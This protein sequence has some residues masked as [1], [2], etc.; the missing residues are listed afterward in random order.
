MRNYSKAAL[1]CLVL[2]TQACTLTLPNNLVKGTTTVT[3]TDGNGGTVSGKEDCN[4]LFFKYDLNSDKQLSEDEYIKGRL[5]NVKQDDGST[6]GTVVATGGV[7][8]E[9][10]KAPTREERREVLDVR[11]IED[12]IRAGFKAMD[13][14]QNGALSREEFLL[15]CG[16]EAT[17]TPKPKPSGKKVVPPQPPV[18]KGECNDALRKW[19]QNGDGAID[20]AEF[21]VF[22]QNSPNAMPAMAC[23]PMD[24]ISN[25]VGGIISN[26]SSETTANVKADV[27]VAVPNCIAP[28]A[29]IAFEKFDFDQNGTLSADEFCEAYSTIYVAVPPVP[30][31]PP[32]WDCK[33]TFLRADVNHD[34]RVDL[35]EFRRA[36][37]SPPP[38]DGM[39]RPAVMPS[40]EEQFRRFESMDANRDK[41]LTPDEFCGW[42]VPPVPPVEPGSCDELLRRDRDNDGMVRWEEYYVEPGPNVKVDYPAYK[43]AQ[44][45]S[46]KSMDRNGD[47]ALGK[48][49]LCGNVLPEPDPN[50][51]KCTAEFKSFDRDGSGQLSYD[52]YAG[53][54]YGQIRFIQAPSQEEAAKFVYEFK[55]RA[56]ALDVDGD[57]Q[58]SL[59]EFGQGCYQ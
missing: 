27:D 48:D 17:D 18:R 40:D 35:E 14:D 8:T 25:Q 36:D 7:Q 47:G 50:T 20:R 15:N 4:A 11:T 44:Y 33:S 13:A 37:Y 30:P 58:L 38:P 53:G 51:D 5:G 29:P 34:G 21:Q 31:T 55:A 39:A 9:E 57:E 26:N 6:G 32:N 22:I 3:G 2:A 45:Q 41:F 19:D 54:R 43:D 28:P 59:K 1:L 16:G 56:R 42:A 24:L 52:E 10:A 12:D 49:E 23:A 46:F